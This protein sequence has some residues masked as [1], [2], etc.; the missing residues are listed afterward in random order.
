MP[1]PKKQT[2]EGQQTINQHKVNIMRIGDVGSNVANLQRQLNQAGAKPQLEVDGWFGE[3]TRVAVVTFQKRHGISAIGIAGPRTQAALA[4][5]LDPKRIGKSDLSRAAKALEVNLASIAA[6]AEVESAGR[7]FVDQRPTILYERHIF[8]RRSPSEQAQQWLLSHPNICNP[9]RG[10]YIGGVAEHRR[11][12]Q[13]SALNESTALESASWGMF[14]I[15]GFHWQNLGYSSVQ[16]YVH[17]MSHSEGRQLDA[18]VR[19]IIADPAL[20]T[21]LRDRKWAAFARI[22]NG[23]AYKDNL[24]DIKLARSY[25][26]FVQSYGDAA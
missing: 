15:M 1:I 13:A 16:E 4:G 25:A 14:Q 10:G 12:Q 18:L 19:F 5:L 17:D 26:Q 24:Y 20:H 8:H 21:A 2:A 11:L 6:V 23:P 3:L 22:Y 7:G 9:K